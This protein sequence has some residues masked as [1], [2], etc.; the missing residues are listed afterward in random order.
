MEHGE[1]RHHH[2]GVLQAVAEPL[3][4]GGEGWPLL[5][6]GVPALA[7]QPVQ[8]ARAVVGRLQPGNTPLITSSS[9]HKY[10]LENTF[11]CKTFL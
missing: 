11:D 10:W 3:E 7:H 5:G 6:D 2:L 9:R 1:R 8:R 4:H